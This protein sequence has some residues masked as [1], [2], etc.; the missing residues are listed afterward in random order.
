[1]AAPHFDPPT[2]HGEL[3]SVHPFRCDMRSISDSPNAAPYIRCDISMEGSSD[4]VDILKSHEVTRRV[5]SSLHFA[6]NDP[7][8]L[9][10]SI[11]M[12]NLAILISRNCTRVKALDRLQLY[13]RPW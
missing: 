10:L 3:P 13:I 5:L 6:V 2:T 4:D 11:D 7:R 12:V 9:T 8:I 1:M